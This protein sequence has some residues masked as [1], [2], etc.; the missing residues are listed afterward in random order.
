MGIR[1]S[2]VPLRAVT[3]HELKGFWSWLLHTELPVNT[4]Y[5][6]GRHAKRSLCFRYCCYTG[7]KV[8]NLDNVLQTCFCLLSRRWLYCPKDPLVWVGFFAS[9]Q[10]VSVCLHFQNVNRSGTIG[11]IRL[12]YLNSYSMPVGL[13]FFF[14]CVIFSCDLEFCFLLFICSRKGFSL[15][16]YLDN[17]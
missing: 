13:A 2:L 9:T 7:H 10:A 12:L 6:S 11:F 17:D 8:N 16:P 5:V 1:R 4:Q 14:V 15:S 3:H